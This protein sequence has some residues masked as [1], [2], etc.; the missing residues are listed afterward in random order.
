M[1][2]LD[3]FLEMMLAERGSSKHTITA[4][5]KDVETFFKFAKKEEKEI[6]RD[7]IKK[8]LTYLN[9]Y[10]MSARTQA[11]KLSSLREFFKF[12]YSERIRNDIPTEDIESPKIEKTLPKY[13]SEVEIISLFGTLK[14][15]ERE[16]KIRL[17][18]LL[19][20]DYATGM[21][22]SELVSLPLSTFNPKQEYLVIKGK[23]EKERIVPINENAKKA[24]IEYLKIRDIYLKGGRESK[25]MFP[26]SSKSGH[27]TRDGFFKMIK[28]IAVKAG[29]EPKKVS[30]HVLRHS[31][32]SHLIAHNANLLSVQQ[33]LGHSDVR[34]TEIYTHILDDRLKELVN[35]AH[36]LSKIEKI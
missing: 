3:I 15:I 26:S 35:S 18:A 4:Y 36:P 14:E 16:N 12:L 13:L 10:Q 9:S 24:L 2:S 23:G 29:I 19:E 5:Q 7:D 25:W 31:F 17:I 32:A 1:Q 27:L 8:F 6:T 30:P 21:R 34:T 11:R 22:V 28:E 33:M 20:L